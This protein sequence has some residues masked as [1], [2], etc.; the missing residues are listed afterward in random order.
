MYAE[1]E[2]FLNMDAPDTEIEERL[3]S[4]LRQQFEAGK[5][6]LLDIVNGL[7]KENESN[8]D[9]RGKLR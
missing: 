8:N 1:L 6:E 2:V 4:E 5:R 3:K 9:S 7:S